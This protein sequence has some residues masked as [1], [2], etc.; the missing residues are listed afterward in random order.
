MDTGKQPLVLQ[1]KMSFSV[2]MP[3]LHWPQSYDTTFCSWIA[4]ASS[5]RLRWHNRYA[6]VL[7]QQQMNIKQLY[8]GSGYF[9]SS[10]LKSTAARFTA[11]VFEKVV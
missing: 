2:A 3:H 9:T 11:T 8:Q 7:M 1:N 10:L 4:A 6:Q 5:S